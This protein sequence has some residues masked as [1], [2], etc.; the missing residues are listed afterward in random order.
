[1]AEEK[2]KSREIIEGRLRLLRRMALDAASGV[3]PQTL[4]TSALKESLLLSGLEAGAVTL[5]GKEGKAKWSIVVGEEK[6]AA[7]LREIEKSLLSRL[8]TEHQ[9]RSLYMTIGEEAP[10]G[11]F[12]YPLK[13]GKVIYGAIS[14]LAQG[15][16]NLAVEE[17]FIS[18]TAALMALVAE[19]DSDALK[20]S[21]TDGIKQARTAINHHV[22]S[23]LMAIS[24]N[25]EIFRSRVTDL[26]PEDLRLLENI[27]KGARQILEVTT[28]LRN[29][30]VFKT[31]TYVGDQ[32][33]LDIDAAP[34]PPED[35]E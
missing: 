1:M 18:A 28:K 13:A 30:K 26:S 17:E 27:E 7:R 14:G 2:Q 29:L 4:L 34:E 5:L 9:V 10:A 16:R 15:E 20:A 8:R 22:N 12:S 33:M 25:L 11:V 31:T 19:R 35:Q 32:D 3:D 24:G 21:W 23:P 6:S